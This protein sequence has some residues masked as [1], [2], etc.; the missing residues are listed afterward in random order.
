M[1]KNKPFAV[2]MWSKYSNRDHRTFKIKVSQRTGCRVIQYSQ[3]AAVWPII[4]RYTVA[5]G[6]IA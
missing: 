1:L 3:L 6:S 4:Y 5:V 2:L